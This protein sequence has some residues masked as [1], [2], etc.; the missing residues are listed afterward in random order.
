M[1]PASGQAKDLPAYSPT[2]AISL[3]HLKLCSGKRD[4]TK[5]VK[6]ADLAT[7]AGI[8]HDYNFLSGIERD[9]EKS[10]KSVVEKGL[11]VDLNARPKGDR[12]QG[13]D[14][15]FAAAGV[16]VIRAPKGMSRSKENKTHRSKSGNR[17][18]IWT[19]EWIGEDKSRTLTQ[20]SAVEPIYRLHPLHESPASRKKRKRDVEVSSVP[21]EQPSNSDA[22]AQ[23]TSSRPLS[24]EPSQGQVA[25]SPATSAPLEGAP[26]PSSQSEAT[27]SSAPRE[28]RYTFYLFRPRT[29]SARR[30]LIPITSSSTLGEVLRG[31]TVEEYPT[32]YYFS[33]R[34]PKLSE[35]FV[36]DEQ[37]RQEEGEQQREFEELMRDVDPEIL[38]RL[39]EDE[40]G[41]SKRGEEVD[42]KKI[43]DVLKQDLGGL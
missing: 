14:Y 10:E 31:N 15:H 37:Y 34:E 23:N 1:N 20:S 22:A 17:N 19:V 6:K 7:P 25:A 41:S 9:L 8:D 5:Y 3:M 30:V 11:D 24:V 21:D 27:A 38:K 33:S 32:I 28:E 18:I 2:I 43:L 12:S 16:K 42:S 29:S 39:K 26:A 4:P 13:M 35:D 40:T 36:L